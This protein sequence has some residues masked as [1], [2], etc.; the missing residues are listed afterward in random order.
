SSA[1]TKVDAKQRNARKTSRVFMGNT[2]EPESSL[3]HRR[4]SKEKLNSKSDRQELAREPRKVPADCVCR[5]VSEVV[6]TPTTARVPVHACRRCGVGASGSTR[7]H[8]SCL[9]RRRCW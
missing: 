6:P 9:Y 3:A 2:A 5:N 1:K 7:G 8:F 4:R